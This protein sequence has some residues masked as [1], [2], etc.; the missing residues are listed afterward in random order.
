M[1]KKPAVKKKGG[2]GKKGVGKKLDEGVGTLELKPL[3]DVGL[4]REPSRHQQLR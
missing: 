3:G 4:S 1:G 2:F